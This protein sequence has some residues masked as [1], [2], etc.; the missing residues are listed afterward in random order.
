MRRDGLVTTERNSS[1]K[2]SV[3]VTLTDEGWQTLNRVMPVAKEIV[4]QVMSSIDEGDAALLDKYLRTL[5]QNAYGGLGNVA[6]RPQ[7]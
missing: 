3:N 2:R 4:D 1:D 6:K 5:R 7:P